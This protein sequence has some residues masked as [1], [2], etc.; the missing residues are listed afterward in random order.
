VSAAASS[1]VYAKNDRRPVRCP[2]CG[3]V[4]YLNVREEYRVRIGEATGRC[5]DCRFP[6]KHRATPAELRRFARWWLDRYSEEELAGLARGLG[7]AGATPERMAANRA[8][9]MRANGCSGS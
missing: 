8:I 1:V 3:N 7:V 2:E 5:H 9:F 4:R 6:N